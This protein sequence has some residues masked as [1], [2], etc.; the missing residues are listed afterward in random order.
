MNKQ[1]SFIFTVIF[2]LIQA[3][4]IIGSFHVGTTKLFANEATGTAVVGVTAPVTETSYLTSLKGYLASFLGLLKN[5]II[6]IVKQAFAYIHQTIVLAFILW[7]FGRI[8]KK[9]ATLAPKIYDSIDHH[10]NKTSLE[11]REAIKKYLDE[12]VTKSI[13]AVEAAFILNKAPL[14][15]DQEEEAALRTQKSKDKAAAALYLVFKELT[16]DKLDRVVGKEKTVEELVGDLLRSIETKLIEKQPLF[17]DNTRETAVMGG[18]SVWNTATMAKQDDNAMKKIQQYANTAALQIE[19]AKAKLP[20]EY[21]E[22][23]NRAVKNA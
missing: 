22:C 15:S 2:I 12:L 8:K 5:T 3:S 4:I 21:L 13:D 14:T 23:I 7:F 1:G 18:S 19:H 10:M 17:A 6:D 16:M 20:Q 11:N 9:W